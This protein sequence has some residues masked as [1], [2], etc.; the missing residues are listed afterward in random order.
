MQAELAAAREELAALVRSAQ[1]AS[2]AVS[3]CVDALRAQKLDVV[4]RRQADAPVPQCPQVAAGRRDEAAGGATAVVSGVVP[5][6]IVVAGSD[7]AAHSGA[8]VEPAPPSTDAQESGGGL[9][10]D[11]GDAALDAHA[12][13]VARSVLMAECSLVL[14]LVGIVLA[15]FWRK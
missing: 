14:S 7:A 11:R 4:E 10:A 5:A 1:W 9:A 15:V 12:A 3:V 13:A 2:G 6:V 8:L